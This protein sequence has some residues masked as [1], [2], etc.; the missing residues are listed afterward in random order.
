[1]NVQ[2]FLPRPCSMVHGAILS[3]FTKR[4]CT[5]GDTT[6]GS[7]APTVQS[8]GSLAEHI[9]HH[10]GVPWLNAF[11][12][13]F[14]S[15]DFPRAEAGCCRVPWHGWSQRK[16]QGNKTQGEEDV[17]SAHRKSQ[18]SSLRSNPYSGLG[19]LAACCTPTSLSH[20]KEVSTMKAREHHIITFP[21]FNLL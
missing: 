7:H 14:T 8:E 2:E 5:V 11:T 17:H 9:Q 15:R 4:H 20:S 1:M 13:I 12:P 3:G 6:Y 16:M 18:R 19:L 10:L 21:N